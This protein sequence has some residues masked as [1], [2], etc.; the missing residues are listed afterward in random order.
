MAKGVNRRVNIYING[1]EVEN[2]VKSIRSEM[3]KLVN[4]QN[5]MTIGSDKYVAHGQK[6]KELKSIVDEHNKSLQTTSK[7]WQ[8]ILGKINQLGAGLGGFS[9]LFAQLNQGIQKLKKIATD[10]AGMDDI[11]SNVM[12]YTGMTRKQVVG[13]ND[14]FKKLDTRTAREELNRLAGEAG[15]LGISGKKKIMEFVDAANIINISLG[16]DLGEDAVKNIGKMAEMFGETD[17]KGLRAAMLATGSAINYLGQNSSAAEQYLMEFTA[18]LSGTA[19]QAKLTQAQ[20]LGYASVLDQNMQ[21]VEM[22]AS[23]MQNLILK[24]MQKPAKFAEMAGLEVKKFSDL[25]KNDANQAILTLIDSLSKKGGLSQLAPI[26]KE[27]GL[28][29]VRA[30]GVISVLANNIDK[31]R[32]EQEKA[33]KAYNEGTSVIDEYNIKNNNMQASL[34]KARKK[35]QDMRLELGEKL[36]PVL[37][38]LTSTSTAGIKLLSKLIKFIG[39]N[40]IA[41][42]AIIAPYTLY[43]AKLLL[44]KTYQGSLNILTK[45][46]NVI[47]STTKTVVYTTSVAYNTMTKNTSRAAAAQRLLKTTFAETP[48]GA[49]LT[50]ITAVGVAIWKYATKTTSAEKAMKEF[51]EQSAK[52]E[53][54]AIYLFDALKKTTEGSAEYKKQLERLK[55]LYPDII[56]AHINEKGALQDI[57]IAYQEVIDSI[58]IKIAEQIKEQKINEAIENEIKDTTQYLEKIR[59][60]LKKQGKS[61]LEISDVIQKITQEIEN[62]INSNDISE[63]ISQDFNVNVHRGETLDMSISSYI[64][65]I[66]GAKQYLKNTIQ[67]IETSF[68]NIIPKKTLTEIEKLEEKLKELNNSLAG[69]ETKDDKKR[70]QAEIKETEKLIE[71]KKKVAN[72]NNNNDNDNNTPSPDEEAEKKWK[73]FYEKLQNFRTKNQVDQLSDFEKEK[74]QITNEYDQMIKEAK[75]FGEKG[76]K[77]ARELEVEKGEAIVAAGKKYLSKYNEVLQKIS[78]SANK[79]IKEDNPLLEKLKISNSTWDKIIQDYEDLLSELEI[80]YSE[81]TDPKEAESVRQTMIDTYNKQLEAV[82]LKT[83]DQVAIVKDAEE[84]ITDT[85]KT[86][87]EKQIDEVQK[88]YDLLIEIAQTSINKLV[89]L[90]PSANAELIEKLK[91]QIEELKKKLGEEIDNITSNSSDNNV[92]EDFFNIDWSTITTDWRTGLKKIVALVEEVYNSIGSI[93]SDIA[94]I[95]NN[96]AESELNTFKNTQDEKLDALQDRYDKGLIS[97]SYYNAEK[98]KLEDET[99]AKEKEIALEQWK[100]NKA[101]YTSEAVIQGTL[102]AIKS[103]ASLPFPYGL[104][105]MALS[106]ATTAV[107]IAAIQ[108]EPA[109][110]AAGGYVQKETIYKAG[111]AGEEWVASNNLLKNKKTAG[112]IAQLE[113]YQRGKQSIFDN[114]NVSVPD[115]KN[116]SQAAITSSNNFVTSK[117]PVVHNYYQNN[118]DNETMTKML[119]EFTDLKS[120]M[121]DPKNRR[122]SIDR[123]LLTEYDEN[124]S[125]LRN[126]SVL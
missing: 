75:E 94:T 116:L 29:G 40:K 47:L 8:S 24:M 114:M 117:A 86:E 15:K 48:W 18:R 58:R 66:S 82:K 73:S 98:E 21:K 122:A 32:T 89:E 10:M 63:Q 91:K 44:V 84:E 13:L 52:E 113:A 72:T 70:I 33:T 31:I 76:K 60:E 20:V 97:E 120:Y 11:Y 85:L 71:L 99:D 87:K 65:N 17:K 25:L 28:D 53:A 34:E 88:K 37:I 118:S 123:K 102:A 56:Q 64:K 51:N 4:E 93:V 62:G 77:I 107:Q 41:V 67:D 55:K 95:Q 12:K 50:I 6:I 69:A 36:Y 80:L 23:A 22:S 74:A 126:K 119:K 35:F 115:R 2:N 59:K 92:W 9:M 101:V 79:E 90:D 112:M 1:Q 111:E 54:Q 46:W 78:D 3:A 103:F 45:A 30:S 110:Y 39:E 104:I 49:I 125:F 83:S 108:S 57:N 19:N 100:R 105:P 26:F 106:L 7:S 43:L 27:M 5:K 96:A 14:D 16:E 42:L 68:K 124:E 61:D 121:K 81:T 109:P 38:K